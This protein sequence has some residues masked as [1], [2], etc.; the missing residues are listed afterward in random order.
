[1]VAVVGQDL[2]VAKIGGRW[3]ITKSTGSSP[4]LGA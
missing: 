4:T 1:V 3:L 2:D